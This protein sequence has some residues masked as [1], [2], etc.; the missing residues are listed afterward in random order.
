M[1]LALKLIPM[2]KL[3]WDLTLTLTRVFL[4]R[5]ALIFLDFD[6]PVCVQGYDPTLGTKTFATVSGALAYY[7]PI[8]GKVFT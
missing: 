8:T 3:P 1:T 4:G 5:D 2:V 6:R 7:N